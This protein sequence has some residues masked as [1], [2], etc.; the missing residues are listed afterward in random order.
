[1]SNGDISGIDNTNVDDLNNVGDPNNYFGK[2]NMEVDTTLDDYDDTFTS[3]K[4]DPLSSTPKLI[5]RNSTS[6]PN[7]TSDKVLY[8]P[9]DTASPTVRDANYY[10]KG[11]FASIKL[12]YIMLLLSFNLL[13]P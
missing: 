9:S 12:S 2:Y 3:L 5:L 11:N 4:E 1:M 10:F 13:I 6:D 8:V 7:L